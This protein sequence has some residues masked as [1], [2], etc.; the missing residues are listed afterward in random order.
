ML[1]WAIYVK[2]N[3]NLYPFAHLNHSHLLFVRRLNE[4]HHIILAWGGEG[5]SF[6]VG[7]VMADEAN[8]RLEGPAAVGAR[9]GGRC[10]W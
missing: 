7:A 10:L 6:L 5:S 3:P 8:L 4:D 2:G 1:K 9:D